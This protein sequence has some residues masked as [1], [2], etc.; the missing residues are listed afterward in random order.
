MT[1]N[2]VPI[3]PDAAAAREAGGN[4]EV[5]YTSPIARAQK[6]QEVS[7]YFRWVEQLSRV[8]NETQDPSIM[9]R[10]D[11]DAAAVDVAQTMGVPESYVADDRQSLPRQ[12]SRDAQARQEQIAAAPAQPDHEGPGCAVKAGMVSHRAGR[13]ATAA[14]QGAPG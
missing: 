2:G 12:G 8:A 11:N 9:D 13:R 3:C 6:M 7:A 5:E 14:A 10:V 1:N 4:Y